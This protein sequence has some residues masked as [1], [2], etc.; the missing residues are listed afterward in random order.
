M[1]RFVALAVE[2]SAGIRKIKAVIPLFGMASTG[3]VPSDGRKGGAAAAAPPLS[4]KRPP[5]AITAGGRF[6]GPGG[7]CSPWLGHDRRVRKR[8]T[9]R[10]FRP[11]A[12]ATP[13][14]RTEHRIPAPGCYAAAKPENNKSGRP[15]LPAAFHVVVYSTDQRKNCIGSM[16]T[17]FL[18]TSKCRCGPLEL[19]VD[20]I[21][22]SSCPLVTFCPL[23]TYSLLQCAYSVS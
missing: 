1:P 3:G 16:R 12:H 10:A 19:P 14:R 6:F 7:I 20:P 18:R 11:R 5:A 8:D 2:E 23:T 13:L 9:I 22:P 17:P 21:R 15:K 4:K